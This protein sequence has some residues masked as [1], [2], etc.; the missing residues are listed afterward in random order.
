MT[1]KKHTS[2]FSNFE[3]GAGW[4]LGYDR[5][6]APDCVKLLRYTLVSRRDTGN[7]ILE[8]YELNEEGRALCE[9][10]DYKPLI[11]DHL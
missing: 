6:F 9:D 1:K 3:K 5:P 4:W 2:V 7:D 11:I 8:R 10:P